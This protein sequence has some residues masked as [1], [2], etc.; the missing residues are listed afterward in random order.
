[1]VKVGAAKKGPAGKG[2]AGKGP[3]N[4]NNKPNNNN[5]NQP[6][7]TAKGTFSF[8]MVTDGC[9]IEHKVRWAQV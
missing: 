4:N 9:Y 6:L 7:R 1:M 5:T 3:R 8:T 2:P